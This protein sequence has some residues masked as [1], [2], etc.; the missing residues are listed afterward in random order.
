MKKKYIKPIF[1]QVKIKF[2]EDALKASAEDAL[3]SLEG[4]WDEFDDFFG[5]GGENANGGVDDDFF[6]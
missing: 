6:G 4:E 1:M 5:D 2:Y 3:G